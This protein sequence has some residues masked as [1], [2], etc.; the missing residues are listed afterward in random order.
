MAQCCSPGNLVTE[1][2]NCTVV[3]VRHRCQCRR[4]NPSSLV[5]QELMQRRHWQRRCWRQ[6]SEERRV[7]NHLK[8]ED[9]RAANRDYA[10]DGST[11]VNVQPATS[12]RRFDCALLIA[13]ATYL[14]SQE[15]TLSRSE[16]CCDRPT[17]RCSASVSISRA[18]NSLSI[19]R[20]AFFRCGSIRRHVSGS[21]PPSNHFFL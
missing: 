3:A 4:C 18:W 9:N 8:L 5:L 20:M 7:R 1:M 6:Q 11:T 21:T 14:M 10:Q 15:L 19:W 17:E 12:A 2:R 13:R 16:I